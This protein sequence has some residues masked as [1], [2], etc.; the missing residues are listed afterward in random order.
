[1]STGPNPNLVDRGTLYP[2]PGISRL[3]GTR[4]GVYNYMSCYFSP[5]GILLT[6]RNF[7]VLSNQR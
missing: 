6:K 5:P 2:V 7:Y 3:I 1:M 4:D